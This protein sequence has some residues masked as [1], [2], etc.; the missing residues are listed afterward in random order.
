VYDRGSVTRSSREYR[1]GRS[2]RRD[3][4]A[5]RSNNAEPIHRL[6]DHLA[7]VGFEAPR[8]LGEVSDGRE[9]QVVC[10]RGG[11]DCTLS[12]M[13]VEERG[14]ESIGILLRRYHDAVR[15]FAA[16]GLDCSTELR[17][18]VLRPLRCLVSFARAYGSRET[19]HVTHCHDRRGKG[20]RSCF[21]PAP[22]R[23]WRRRLYPDGRRAR[24]RLI[25]APAAV[26]S[27]EPRAICEQIGA[28]AVAAAARSKCYRDAR[29]AG[30][31]ADLLSAGS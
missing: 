7:N 23:P 17:G 30:E 21:R 22:L 11:A 2:L 4:D 12:R 1:S 29:N 26:V 25:P 28:I 20:S 31:L 27:A 19:V 9:T 13:V 5:S 24:I 16:D 14:L 3:R 6:L 10:R 15:S 18:K 8:P